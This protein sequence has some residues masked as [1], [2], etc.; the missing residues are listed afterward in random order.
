MS[1]ERNGK[2]NNVINRVRDLKSFSFRIYMFLFVDKRGSVS[3]REF[4]VVVLISRFE[5]FFS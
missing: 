5:M 1:T 3:R 2:E 4:C